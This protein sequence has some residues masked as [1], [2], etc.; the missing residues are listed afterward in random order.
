MH[1]L[2][3]AATIVESVLELVTTRGISDVRTVRL[4]VGELTCVQHEQ[5]RFCYESLAGQ[6][7]I[8]GSALEIELVPAEVKCP[9]C[10]YE[11][12]PR[13]WDEALAA[14]LVPTLQCPQCGKATEAV[15]GH[16]CAIRSI[17][18]AS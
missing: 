3:I 4:A 1:E 10:Q 12:A 18:Y 15:R 2:S 5:L 9:H 7:E 13:Y 17:Q 11:G 8:K 6:T 14:E 16:E